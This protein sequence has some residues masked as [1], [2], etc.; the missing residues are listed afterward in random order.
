MPPDW[1]RIREGRKDI[2]DWVIHWTRGQFIE[3]RYHRP[4]DILKAIIREGY[5]KPSMAP[6]HRYSTYRGGQSNTI[7]G[8]HPAVC[9]TDQPLAAFIQSCRILGRYQPYAVGLQKRNLFK[10]GARPVIY[11][12]KDMLGRL[13]DTDKYLW[14][15]Y[16][17]TPTEFEHGD[18]P[19]DWTH[20]REW[21][22]RVARYRTWGMTPDEGIPLILPPDFIDGQFVTPIP[23]I[24]VDT[25]SEVTELREC[26]A[27]LPNY[28]GGNGFIKQLYENFAELKMLSLKFAAEQLA[29]GDMRFARLEDIPWNEVPT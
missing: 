18:F 24:L 7:Q 14:V 10:Y 22:A 27:G 21:R 3:K 28:E 16:D 17:P 9:F 6:R 19:I 12:D 26:L 20:E 11:G 4:F 29:A 15:P 2:T 8:P 25:P 23:V 1:K 13:R 5:L